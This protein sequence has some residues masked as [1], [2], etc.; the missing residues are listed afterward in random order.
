VKPLRLLAESL[1]AVVEW[2][3]GGLPGPPGYALRWLYYKL[4]LRALGWGTLIDVGVRIENP[5]TVSIGRRVWI[6]RGVM[7]L[8]AVADPLKGRPGRWVRRDPE[9]EGRVVIGDDCHIAP[10]CLLSGLAGLRIGRELTLAAGTLVYSLSH[11]FRSLDSGEPALFTPRVAPGLQYMI[12]GPV[13]IGD[14]TGTGARSTLLPGSRLAP[15]S[16]LQL[17]GV[18]RGD[19]EPGLVYR[20]N[21]A[22]P[23]AARAA[24][25]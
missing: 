4:I 25:R 1:R 20:G 17:G 13:E 11:H 7:I 22:E 10:G 24:D 21:P 9:V 15:G 12:A 19:T 8:G 14:R 5:R 3:I 2:L 16:F 23:V 18:L 6:D